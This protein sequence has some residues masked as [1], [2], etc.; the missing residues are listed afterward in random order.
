MVGGII[1]PDIENTKVLIED[2]PNDSPSGMAILT[3]RNGIMPDKNV[4]SSGDMFLI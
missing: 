4:V 1:A 2:S 3:S